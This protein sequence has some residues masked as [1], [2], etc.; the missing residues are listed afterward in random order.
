MPFSIYL[1]NVEPTQISMTYPRN[2]HL[3]PLRWALVRCF[4]FGQNDASYAKTIEQ[5][6]LLRLHPTLTDIEICRR[7]RG[8]LSTRFLTLDDMS[9]AIHCQSKATLEPVVKLIMRSWA[10]VFLVKFPLLALHGW[11]HIGLARSPTI[12]LLKRSK[13]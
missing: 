13:V 10:L 5:F 6:L 2:E 9:L 1:D 7:Y 12:L 3:R 8:F 4:N 11:E